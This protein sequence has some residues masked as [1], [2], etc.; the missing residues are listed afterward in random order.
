MVVRVKPVNHGVVVE[1]T[2]Y[3]QQVDHSFGGTV[4]TGIGQDEEG[5]PACIAH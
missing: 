2:H 4:S 3:P 1:Q 5:L